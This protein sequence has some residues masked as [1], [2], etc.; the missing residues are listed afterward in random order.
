M[1][2]LETKELIRCSLWGGG[3][4][5]L[6]V[7]IYSDNPCFYYVVSHNGNLLNGLSSSNIDSIIQSC[8]KEIKFRKKE[9]IDNLKITSEK[10]V[11]E[12]YKLFYPKYINNAE[13][14]LKTLKELKEL[15]EV[16]CEK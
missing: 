13:M 2:V 14:F 15:K 5:T 6:Y 7:Q 9:F 8:R 3:F 11:I 1:S 16:N 10:K 12:I 4:E